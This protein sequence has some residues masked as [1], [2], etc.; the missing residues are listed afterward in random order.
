MH[1]N[2]DSLDILMQSSYEYLLLNFTIF[3]LLALFNS[4]ILLLNKL[5][6][7]LSNFQKEVQ[8]KMKGKK[9]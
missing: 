1:S 2:E 3:E 4:R 5:N 9:I 6:I 7:T 8:F